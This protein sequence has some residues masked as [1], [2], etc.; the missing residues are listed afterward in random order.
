MCVFLTLRAD[1]AGIEKRFDASLVE[2]EDFG[3]VYA[4]SAFEYPP[5]PVITADKPQLIQRFH[6]GLIPSWVRDTQ[7]AVR[8]KKSTINA[9]AET[10]LEKPSFRQAARSR[11]CLVLA[12]GFFEHHESQGKK[13]PHFIQ[14]KNGEPFAIAGIWEQW[15]DRETGEMISTFS[16]ITT[17]A[18]PLLER[19]H[20]TRKKMPVILPVQKEHEW[21]A[22]GGEN[23]KQLLRP[24]PEESMESWTVSKMISARGGERDQ[25]EVTE[26]FFYPELDGTKRLFEL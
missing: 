20:N 10:L 16:V 9:R 26:P 8:I 14:L 22:D 24:Y 1:R 6:W 21:L 17:E 12:D 13:Y 11:H 3:P 15:T 23:L 2:P 25:P 4:V 19:I 18:N 7:D 5:W